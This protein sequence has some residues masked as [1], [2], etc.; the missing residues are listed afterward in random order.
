M[1]YR[2]G[3]VFHFISVL[4]F[5]LSFL[6]IYASL[7][8]IVAYQLDENGG[9]LK[10]VPKETFFYSGMIIFIV[11]NVIMI[12]PGKLIEN[13]STANLKRLFPK[14]ER[15]SDLIIAWI[16]SFVGVINISLTIMALFIHSINNQNEISSGEFSFFFYLIPI[17]FVIWIGG[18]FWILG[19]KFKEVQSKSI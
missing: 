8:D 12:V 15:L 19:Q 17:F 2:F 18:L 11:L 10:S 4:V 5:I 9:F 1:Y 6:Y 14:G 13:Q 7:S 3:K 16:Y